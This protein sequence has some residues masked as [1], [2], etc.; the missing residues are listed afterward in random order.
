M[1]LVGLAF[2]L[3]L[4]GLE[5]D[6][7]SLRGDLLRLPLLG[8]SMRLDRLLVRLQDTTAEIRVRIAVALL[9]GFVALAAEAGLE[10]ILGAFIAGALLG[11]IDRDTVSHP[12]FRLKLDAI[13]YGLL[14]PVFFVASGLRF[15]LGALTDN[16]SALIR[17]PLLLLALLAARGVPALLYRRTLGVDGTAVAALL[18]ATSLPFIV[19]ATQIGVGIGVIQPATAA[20]LVSAGLLS[21]IIFPPIALARLRRATTRDPAIGPAAPNPSPAV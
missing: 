15:D 11:T 7:I 4:A 5:I 16:P 17:V 20:A 9:I 2:L 21:V 1:S 14:I 8:F 10:T 3:F 6:L 13:G 12:H 18:Q 19:T